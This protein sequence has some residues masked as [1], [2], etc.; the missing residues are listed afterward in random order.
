MD[1]YLD[2]Y[3]HRQTALITFFRMDK[4][5]GNAVTNSPSCPQSGKGIQNVIVG[6]RLLGH[7]TAYLLGGVAEG[8]FYKPETL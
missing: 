1:N 3:L 7:V 8:L 2:M 6:S 4:G 5:N